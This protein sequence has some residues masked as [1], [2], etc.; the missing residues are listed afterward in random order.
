MRIIE[1][2]FEKKDDPFIK[3]CVKGL[4]F[5]VDE[6]S[7]YAILL[8]RPSQLNLDHRFV[9]FDTTKMKDHPRLQ[10]LYF[11]LINYSVQLKMMRLVKEGIQQLVIFDEAWK[12][13]ESAQTA[14]LVETL[15]REAR[16]YGT[17]ICCISQSAKDFTENQNVKI[18]PENAQIKMVLHHDQDKVKGLAELGLNEKECQVVTQMKEKRDIFFK[19]GQNSTVLKLEASKMDIEICSTDSESLKKYQPICERG[20]KAELIKELTNVS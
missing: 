12:I 8:N 16:R 2:E 19:A 5:Y 10:R 1:T 6:K 13:L 20:D 9:V 18:I 4:R 11:F 17:K 3:D 7:A 14:S 15:Y